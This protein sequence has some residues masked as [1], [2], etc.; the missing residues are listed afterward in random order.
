MPLKIRQ[1]KGDLQ[2]AGFTLMQGRGKGSHTVWE[3]PDA[4]GLSVTLAGQDGDDG[5]RYQERD[6]KATIANAMQKQ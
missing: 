6:V 1:L 3:H 5:K 2:R 4:P